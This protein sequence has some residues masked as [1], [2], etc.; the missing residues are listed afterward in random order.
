MSNLNLWNYCKKEC[1]KI[2]VAN[3]TGWH[4]YEIGDIVGKIKALE[5]PQY[6]SGIKHRYEDIILRPKFSTYRS[7]KEALTITTFGPR[8]FRLPIIP[9]NMKSVIDDKLALMMAKNGYFYIMHRF[10]DTSAFSKL[11][12]EKDCLSISVGI[13]VE[14]RK[15]LKEIRRPDYVTID[16]AHGHCQAMKEMIAFIHKELPETFVIAGN[17]STSDAVNDLQNW[18]ADAIKAGISQGGACTTYG[19]TGFG[20]S[21]CSCILECASVAHAP[22]IADGG[23]RCNGDITKA[24]VAGASM[25]MVGSLFA[26]CIDSP[27]EN[28]GEWE[29]VGTLIPNAKKRYFGSASTMNKSD[30]RHIEGQIIDIPCNHMTYEQKLQELEADMQSAMSYGGCKTI[31]DFKNVEWDV[32][33]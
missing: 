3:T 23:I 6:S 29:N 26:A 25:V 8:Q 14:D 20:G 4:W 10:G 32:V 19:K 16:I 2:I 33:Y 24:L 28:I 1:I 30:W 15:L 11:L 21:M 18:G 9:A 17:V 27:A 13:K 7:R 5:P 22:I 12:D 31:A